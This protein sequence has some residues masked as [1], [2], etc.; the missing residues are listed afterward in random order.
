MSQLISEGMRA[1]TFRV[2]RCR[3]AYPAQ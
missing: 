3:W 1:A 2:I